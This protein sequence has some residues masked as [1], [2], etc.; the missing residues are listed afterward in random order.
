MISFYSVAPD[1]LQSI[2]N[3][4]DEPRAARVIRLSKSHATVLAVDIFKLRRY[5]D[6]ED[7]EVL[8]RLVSTVP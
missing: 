2:T 6:E 7:Y 5:I 1:E 4:I 3:Q 8:I